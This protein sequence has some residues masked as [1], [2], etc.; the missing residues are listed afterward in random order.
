MG[1]STTSSFLAPDSSLLVPCPLTSA[2]LPVPSASIRS[3]S[4]VA[5]QTVPSFP[6][7]DKKKDYIVHFART[8]VD[9]ASGGATEI[10]SD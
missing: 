1:K 6:P 3:L 2:V 4:L 9:G 7:A 10:H 8:A 5:G